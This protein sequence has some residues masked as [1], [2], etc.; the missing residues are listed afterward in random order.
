MD[1]ERARG[2]RVGS[3][4]EVHCKLLS[5]ALSARPLR[6]RASADDSREARRA[7][8]AILSA[9]SPLAV[10]IHSLQHIGAGGGGAGVYKIDT[11]RLVIDGKSIGVDLRGVLRA[12]GVAVAHAHR[13]RCVYARYLTLTAHPTGA[14][15]PTPK[16]K[17]I[18]TLMWHPDGRA[19][20]RAHTLHLHSLRRVVSTQLHSGR[21]A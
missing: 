4:L 1:R 21:P 6:V 14:A 17:P 13:V 18:M 11:I 16:P 2:A 12:F 10:V 8:K 9:S 7:E 5:A 3:S 19:L 15:L 20:T